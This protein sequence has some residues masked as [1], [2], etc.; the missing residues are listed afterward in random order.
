MYL[1]TRGVR[2]E[3]ARLLRCSEI[4]RHRRQSRRSAAVVRRQR[5]GVAQH[6]ST[7]LSRDVSH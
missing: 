2:A 3:L 6:P 4:S 5:S 7:A 1:Q